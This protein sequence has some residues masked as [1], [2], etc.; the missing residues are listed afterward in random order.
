MKKKNKKLK[1]RT[2][3]SALA[4]KKKRRITA[5]RSS[6]LFDTVRG[7]IDGTS[8]GYAF[9]IPE[10]GGGDIF[11]PASDL[12]GAIHGDTVEIVKKIGRAHV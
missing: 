1:K 8:R 7:V 12:M 3:G 2:G 11:I 5:P 9:L 6:Q 4:E 10:E